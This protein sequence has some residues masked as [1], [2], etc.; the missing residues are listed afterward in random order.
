MMDNPGYHKEQ[1]VGIINTV[2]SKL[3][4]SE[5]DVRSIFFSELS[6]LKEIIEEARN[7]IKAVRPGDIKDKHLPMVTDELDAVVTATE[8]ATGTI[9]DSCEAVQAELK[10]MPPEVSAKVEAAITK[11]F[12]ACSFQDITGQRITKVVKTLKHIDEKVTTLLAVLG[13]KLPDGEKSEML[14]KP[15]TDADLLNGPQLPGKGVTQDD[16]DRILAEF[17]G[18]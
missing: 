11:V 1:V 2:I 15:V 17:D 14:K 6:K 4:R 7:E 5:G 16:I 12:E 10:N 3:S 9:M 13:A 8:E 18:K